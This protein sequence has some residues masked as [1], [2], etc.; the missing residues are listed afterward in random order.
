M[1]SFVSNLESAIDGTVLSADKIQTLHKDRPLWVRYDLDKIKRSLQIDNLKNRPHNIWRYKELLPLSPEDSVISLGEVVTPI[2][3]CE[4]LGKK[5]GLDKLYIKDESSLPTGSFKS[6]GLVMAVNMAKKFGVKTVA[7][8]T[9]GNAGGAMA[10]Y[11]ARAGMDAYV[12]MPEDTPLINK[13]EC[14]VFGAKAFL[15]NGLIGDCGKIV[16]DG[17]DNIGWFDMSTLK[18]PYRIE[19]KKTMGLEI[20]E[21]LDWSFPDVV[22]YP[23]GGGTGLIGIWKAFQELTS[24][25][26]VRQPMPRMVA[27][28]TS[29]CAPVVKAFL[30]GEST[31]SPWPEPHTRA[32]GLNVPSPLGGAWMLSILGESNGTALTVPEEEID[33]AKERLADLSGVPVGPEAAAAWRGLE[34]LL[35][36]GWINK[37]ERVA[38]LIT[39]DDRRYR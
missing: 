4:K 17:K 28:Q 20:A 16:R 2:I 31:T 37:G 29:G 14:K 23:T 19:G 3:S 13:F 33:T 10:A 22:V 25:D 27:V 39:G 21:Q 7:I 26:W 18:E 9:A 12:F 35:E 34:L 6:R 24:L 30:N 36:Q 8:P 32:L 11:A 38:V 1:P 15:I 5:Y